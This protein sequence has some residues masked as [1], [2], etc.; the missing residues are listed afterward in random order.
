MIPHEK[1]YEI[2]V[3]KFLDANPSVQRNLDQLDSKVAEC[4]GITFEQY[5][6]DELSKA[7]SQYSQMIGKDE[8]DLIIELC[9]TTQEE[10]DEMLLE[11][12]KD[13]ANAIGLEWDEYQK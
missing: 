2:A 12:H 5:R 9:A 11:K 3:K 1:R 13:I 7:F 6:K 10:K 4:L 8:L